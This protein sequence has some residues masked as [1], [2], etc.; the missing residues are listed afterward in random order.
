[1]GLLIYLYCINV[2]AYFMYAADKRAAYF[3]RWRTPEWLL[4][5]VAIVGG[6]FGALCGMFFFRHKTRHK[7]FL[8]SVPI[9]LLIHIIAAI[10]IRYETNIVRW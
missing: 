7:K 4:L 1:M 3:N 5:A 2:I 8:I 10:I 9:F 6:S